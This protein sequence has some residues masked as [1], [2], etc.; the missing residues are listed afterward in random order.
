MIGFICTS[1]TQESVLIA[2]GI[3]VLIV[4]ALTAFAC[5]TKIDFTGMGPYLFCMCLGLLGLGLVVS[6]AGAFGLSSSPAWQTLR[7][8]YAAIGAVLFSMYLVF[9]TQLIV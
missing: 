1:Y 6:I 8:V 9:D 5:Q 7:L 3:T 2:L 4:I